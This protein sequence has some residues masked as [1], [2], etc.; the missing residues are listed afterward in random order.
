MVDG[1]LQKIKELN[2]TKEN[3]K[4]SYDYIMKNFEGH[5]HQITSSLLM[6]MKNYSQLPNALINKSPSYRDHLWNAVAELYLSPPH[7]QPFSSSL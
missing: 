1:S 6:N 3:L 2:Q 4:L 7:E 5:G